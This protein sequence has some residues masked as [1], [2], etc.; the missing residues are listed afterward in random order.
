MDE[1]G[2]V[3]LT[4]QGLQIGTGAPEDANRDRVLNERLLTV[5][6][7]RRELPEGDPVDAGRWLLISTSA[8]ADI[9]ATTLTDS[10]KL[11]GAEC[12]TMLLATACRPCCQCRAAARSARC[13]PVYRCGRAHWPEKRQPG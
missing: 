11:L 8:T 12:T 3:L 10:L 1:H 2:T 9:V 13:R 6:W 5:D 4:M 7:Q